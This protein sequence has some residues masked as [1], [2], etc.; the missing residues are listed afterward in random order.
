LLRRTRESVPVI[1]MSTYPERMT[2]D[3]P[4]MGINWLPAH[5]RNLSAG[6]SYTQAVPHAGTAHVF[7]TTDDSLGYAG[8]SQGLR[9]RASKDDD[10]P[11]CGLCGLPT[12][13]D[14][15]GLR[16]M[17]PADSQGRRDERTASGAGIGQAQ[18]AALQTDY[19]ARKARHPETYADARI[20]RNGRGRNSGRVAQRQAGEHGGADEGQHVMTPSALLGG[21]FD[22]S[23]GTRSGGTR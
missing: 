12:S 20:W 3:H 8:N 16:G 14:L 15:A 18:S 7:S 9:V 17:A 21:R 19:Q 6:S 22:R 2:P 13:T 10:C 11:G 1:P 23:G 4:K 5:F